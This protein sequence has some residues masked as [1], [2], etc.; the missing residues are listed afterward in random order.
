VPD[1]PLI[2]DGIRKDAVVEYWKGKPV[3]FAPFNNC[4]GCFHRDPILL[5]KMSHEHPEKFEWFAERER[6]RKFIYDR[7]KTERL[8]YDDIKKHKMQQE[9]TFEDFNEC[10]SGYCGL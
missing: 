6:G 5:N 4:I 3:K 1:F 10:D 8:T 9:L 7:W 2:R